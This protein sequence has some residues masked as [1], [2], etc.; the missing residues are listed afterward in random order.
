MPN[1]QILVIL[2]FLL[3]ASTLVSQSAEK[4][5]R[6]PVGF[7]KTGEFL[8]LSEDQKDGYAMGFINGLQLSVLLGASVDRADG[9]N[10]CIQG[11]KPNQIAAI[12][13]KYVKDHP[14]N[15]HQRFDTESL[16]ALLTVCYAKGIEVQTFPNK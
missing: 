14:E 5:V 10:E 13:E 12:L 2:S 9:I 3:V 8:N 4:T 6:V 11:M 15:W 1:K 16:N 7:L